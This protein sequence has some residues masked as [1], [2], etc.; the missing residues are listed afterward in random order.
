V[1]DQPAKSGDDVVVISEG[2]TSISTSLAT[3]KHGTSL[4]EAEKII[5]AALKEK[6]EVVG[7]KEELNL[8]GSSFV[9]ISV[10]AVNIQSYDEKCMEL[11]R[12]EM[13]EE[14]ARVDAQLKTIVS[15]LKNK[16]ITAEEYLKLKTA[17]V[18]KHT[19]I[20]DKINDAFFERLKAIA[21]K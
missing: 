12:L 21:P 10:S 14:Q 15:R 7:H 13:A 4:K 17:E 6:R 8:K 18:D 9:K 16:E 2:S 19:E 3:I 5:E 11:Q 20:A 1:K